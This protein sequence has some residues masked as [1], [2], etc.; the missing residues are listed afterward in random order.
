MSDQRNPES[1]EEAIQVG[2]RDIFEKF[3]ILFTDVKEGRASSEMTL[4]PQHRN[5]YGM[6]YGGIMFHLADI[7][8]GMAFLSAGGNGVTVSGN[9]N[10][11]RGAD[12]DAKKLACHAVVKKAGKNLFFIDADISDDSG[13]VL[14]EYSFVFTNLSKE[15]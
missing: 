12:P 11:L 7:T 9:V 10:F 13:S 4:K 1:S 15:V 6:P 14:S 3:G 5:V 8:S 2:Q